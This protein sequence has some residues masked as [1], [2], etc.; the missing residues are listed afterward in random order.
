MAFSALSEKYVPRSGHCAAS[1]GTLTVR[2]RVDTAGV[3]V[4]IEEFVMRSVLNRNALVQAASDSVG[5][6]AAERINV[7]P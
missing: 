7:P 4:G 2:L 5:I 1:P 3:E 6:L